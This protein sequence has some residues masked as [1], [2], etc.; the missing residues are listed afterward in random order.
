MKEREREN[1]TQLQVVMS[2]PLKCNQEVAVEAEV[3]VQAYLF[4]RQGKLSKS[5]VNAMGKVVGRVAKAGTEV[6]VHEKG[7]KVAEAKKAPKDTPVEVVVDPEVGRI[8]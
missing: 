8:K 3:A 6:S 7:T 2:T 1:Q 5:I 4:H